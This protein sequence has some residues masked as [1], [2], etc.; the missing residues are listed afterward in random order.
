[1][2]H[3][4]AILLADGTNSWLPWRR[5]QMSG[6]GPKSLFFLGLP[7]RSQLVCVTLSP[8][9]EEQQEPRTNQ[10]KTCRELV[11]LYL[12]IL[13][14][15]ALDS[16]TDV[17]AVMSVHFLQRGVLQAFAIR[18]RLQLGG[19]HTAFPGDLQCCLSYSLISRLA[20]SWNKAGLYLIS[21]AD[22]LTWRGTLSAVS[23]EM[24]T[25]GDRLSLSIEASAVRTPP[26]T[27]D[28]LGLPAPVLQ[29]FCSD[30]DFILDPSS[31]GGPVWCHVLPSMKKGQIISISRQLPRDGPFRTYGDLQNHWN[32]LYGYRLPDLEGGGVYCSVYFRPVGEKVFTYPLSCIR[33]QPVQRCPRGDLQGAL[34][35]FLADSSERLQ[36]VC[37]FPTRLTSKP[38]Y[39]TAG[40]TTAASMQVLSLDQINL[41]T[42][43][44]LSQPAPSSRAD[45][46]TWVSLSQQGGALPGSRSG[47]SLW[48]R[49]EAR[50]PSARSPSARSPS[51][52]P[53]SSQ[54]QHQ[55]D[56]SRFVSSFF[57][58]FQPASSLPPLPQPGPVPVNPPPKLVPI[59]RNNDPTRRLSV[60]LLRVQKQQNRGMEDKR[61]LTLPL[62]VGSRTTPSS[63]SASSSAAPLPPPLIVPRFARRPKSRSAAVPQPSGQS[64]VTRIS[65]LSPVF[66][67]KAAIIIPP[68]T[69]PSRTSGTVRPERAADRWKAA[70]PESIAPRSIM[71][72][73]RE[74]GP[75]G[76]TEPEPTP[77][78]RE[79]A[80]SRKTVGFDL[81]EK[82][83]KS[84]VS[85]EDV[86]KMARSNQWSSL[87]GR[88]LLLWLR[89]RGIPVSSKL[90]K[91][92][93]M[94]KVM[95]CLAEA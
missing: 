31:T 43:P 79:T 48:Y 47:N 57:Q 42:R 5:L 15:P 64:R 7:D 52:H 9:E 93:L 77:P 2:L 22:F 81:K 12:D 32:R 61:R 6:V 10:I 18:N 92:E 26:P 88:S 3:K 75:E 73:S 82:H 70:G 51:A 11:L 17:T 24:N 45:P 65:S 58:H 34:A 76:S 35:R 23:L 84:K 69:K 66:K 28:D 41:T 53:S 8:Q 1:M 50:S 91:E 25:S 90:R 83:N 46:P 80:S 36:S 89:N 56:H 29:R 33:L 13:A 44:V 67:A 30:P 38:S 16:I 49:P 95:S 68:R 37:G 62:P 71:K 20:P 78:H 21:G 94:M 27:L 14:C 87:S 63:S 72:T 60:A 86:E 59:F 4:P 85:V 39:P 54:N 19:P 55:S 40:L 74:A